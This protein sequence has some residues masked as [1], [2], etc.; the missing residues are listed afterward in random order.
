MTTKFDLKKIKMIRIIFLIAAILIFAICSI[1]AQSKMW[2]TGY[3]AGWMQG[4]NNDGYLTTQNIDFSAMSQII[5]FS[6]VPN[7][8]GTIDSTSNSITPTNSSTLIAAAHAAGVKVI[9]CVGGW[10][11]ETNFMS[12][13][14]PAYLSTFVNNLV[15]FI[16]SRGYDG[17]DIDWETLSSSDASQYSTFITTLRTALNKIS[18]R[19]LLTAATAWQPSI[20]ASLYSQ[21]DQINLMTYDLSGAWQGWV[22]WHNSPIYDG[23][24]KFPSTGGAVP[25]INGMVSSFTS[26]GV[27]A[28]K[29]GIG[30]DFYGYI[31]S[32]GSGTPTGGVSAPDQSWS[33]A[34]TVQ[35]N[36][37]YYQ[38]M[39]QYYQ[40][41]NDKWDSGAQAAYISIVDNTNSANDKFI[42]YDNATTAQSKV[43]YVKS[44]GLGGMIIWE[45]GAGYRSNMPAGQQQPLLEAIKA[46]VNGGTVVSN[47]DTTAPVI[48]ITSP[49]NGS[50]ISGSFSLSANASD[51]V[52]VASVV[53]NI[54][55]SQTGSV[56]TTAPFTLL[57]NTLLLSNGSHTISATAKDAAGNSA[58]STISVTVSNI[59]D[60]TPPVVSI[61]SPVTGSTLSNSVSITASASD[62]V[63]IASVIFEV[64]GLQIGN[65]LSAA[66][67]S[68]LWNTSLASNGSHI[69]TAIAKD[70]AGNTTTSSSVTVSISNNAVVNNTSDL[71]I[72]QDNLN[73]WIDASWGETENYSSTQPVYAGSNAVKVVQGAWGAL[74]LLSGSWSSPVLINPANYQSLQF[75]VYG[76]ST[77]LNLSIYFENNSKGYFPAINYGSIPANQWTVIT[78]PMYTINPNNL[79]I[80]DLV[81]QDIS[82]KRLTYD[83]DNIVLKGSGSIA[84]SSD[85]PN[86]LLPANAQTDV[87]TSTALEWN[88][89]TSAVSYHVKVSTDQT[90]GTLFLDKTGIADTAL[91]VTGLNTSTSYYW[92]V[93][94]VNSSGTETSSQVL[95]FTTGSSTP[96]AVASLPVYNNAL[97]S[98]WINTSWGSTVNFTSTDQVNQ[99]S[100]NSI[101][102]IQNAWGGFS[103]HDGNWGSNSSVDNQTYN[104]VQF[105]VFSTST[106]ALSILLENDGGGTFPTI[107]YGT[108]AAN[109]WT[110]ITIPLSQLNPNNN[111]IERLDIMETS[112]VQKTFYIDNIN[113]INSSSAKAVANVKENNIKPTNFSLSQNYPNPFNPSTNINFSLPS[114]SYVTLNIY[115]ILGEKVTTLVDDNL[116]AGEH[117]VTFHADN[118]ASGIYIYQLRAGNIVLQKKMNLLK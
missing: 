35:S 83:I 62:N 38:I 6:L 47:I 88:S 9:I 116:S 11:S 3:Y 36:V 99:G 49:S 20:F 39:D 76:E 19:P 8:D 51:N 61:T 23:G 33:S 95:N 100:S 108:V 16:Q 63:G 112:G 89:V 30:M 93:S 97:V 113:F 74:R 91:N 79:L 54:D 32:G 73:G 64:D 65:T 110:V 50:T 78:I 27:P 87:S 115:N 59:L 80:R 85:A 118:L 77:S 41:S 5:H 96:T 86:L 53:F 98:P 117:S 90:F 44:N 24:I 46:A 60:T 56:L 12:A 114:T 48:T 22:T 34:P 107:D 1:S 55:G 42:S 13:T 75:A 17:I 57:L 102:V 111:L 28:N 14:S 105:A 4:Q 70:A 67:Y 40:P 45:L 66:P 26:A 109:S 21:F 2:V 52:G 37:P 68:V 69:I 84:S 7:A 18:P 29:L 72:Y 104:A 71:T 92:K 25:S 94:S 82:G 101:K 106:I 58:T 10:N 43:N 103:L 15:S 31:W 81:I